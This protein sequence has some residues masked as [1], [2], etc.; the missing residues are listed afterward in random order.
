MELYNAFT[1][2]VWECDVLNTRV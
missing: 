2:N 1:V